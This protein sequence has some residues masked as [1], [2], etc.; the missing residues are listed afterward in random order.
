MPVPAASMT[1]PEPSSPRDTHTTLNYFVSTDGEAPYFYLGTPPE[2]VPRTN[3]GLDRRPVVVHDARGKLKAG[4]D[5]FGLDKTGFEFLRS[6]SEEKDFADD[7]RIKRVYFREVEAMLKKRTGAKRIIIFDHLRRSAVVDEGPGK[8]RGPAHRVHVD[9][10]LE[11]GPDCV[12]HYMGQDAERLLQGR[13][14]IINVWRPI[15]NRVAH[16]PLAVMD[17]RSLNPADD[18]VSNTFIPQHHTGATSFVKYSP[19]HRWYYL[20]DQSPDEVALFKCFDSD[21]TEGIARSAPHSAF[22]D[23]SSPRDAPQRQSFEVR[24]LVFDEE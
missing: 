3:A 22:R 1:T 14:R 12:R 11:A 4:E 9:Q 13:V 7:E 23:L 5:A 2:G 24:A 8:P 20:A 6:P 16:Q 17:Y 19:T 18:L 15:E 21:T 10:T